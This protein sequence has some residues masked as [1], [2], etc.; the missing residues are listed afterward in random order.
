MKSQQ[1]RDK[2]LSCAARLFA[3]ARYD[4]VLMEDIA[5]EAGV[6]KGTLYSHFADKDAL[7]FAV[8]FDGI[9]QLNDRLRTAAAQDRQPEEQVRAVMNAILSFFSRNRVFFRLL[10]MEDAKAGPG[11]SESRQRWQ[12]ERTEQID[13]IESVLLRGMTTGDFHVPHPRLQAFVLRGM[14]RSVL[15]SS[16]KLSVAEMV[17]V[18]VDTFLYGTHSSTRRPEAPA[19]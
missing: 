6:A 16:E 18:I 15:T 1:R 10:S 12:T 13:V 4:E 2:I 9:S 17:D 14:V 7:Y 5:R 8:V 19:P 3:A 11:G